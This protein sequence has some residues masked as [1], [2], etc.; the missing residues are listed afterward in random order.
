MYAGRLIHTNFAA[1]FAFLQNYYDGII[2]G[3]EIF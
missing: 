2:T 1:L 3:L